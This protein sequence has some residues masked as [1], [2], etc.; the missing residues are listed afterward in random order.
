MVET[1]LAGSL[2]YSIHFRVKTHFKIRSGL[3]TMLQCC[4]V[5]DIVSINYFLT[6]AYGT[7]LML[8]EALTF[9]F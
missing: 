4:L 5:C 2:Q 3:G 7:E 6:T 1:K 9:S 8:Y